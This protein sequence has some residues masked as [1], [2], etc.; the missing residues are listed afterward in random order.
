MQYTFGSKKHWRRTMWNAIASRIDV[1]AREA[2]VL[3]LGGKEDL[4][5]EVA[6]SK[7]FKQENLIF[8]DRS[9]E[10]VSLQRSRG[11]LAVSADFVETCFSLPPSMK[12]HAVFGD[13]CRGLSPA[14]LDSLYFLL[15]A[16]N[17]ESSVFAWNFLR[18][19]DPQW[20]EF[21]QCFD[22][23]QDIGGHSAKH[24]GIQF[25]TYLWIQMSTLL[26][27]GLELRRDGVEYVGGKPM[28]AQEL[29]KLV[30][31]WFSAINL[32]GDFAT[33]SYRSVAKQTFDSVI[34]KNICERMD[35]DLR[36][37]WSKTFADTYGEP[38]VKR[39]LAASWAHRT[40]R[41]NKSGPYATR[42][43]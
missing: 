13:F 29:Q 4:D 25:Q 19:R 24:R 31:S 23:Q 22:G 16:P 3:Y 28:S 11:T 38:Q 27:P 7:G 1:P 32:A 43:A 2:V 36:A 42:A 14:F 8:V 5:R 17:L 9:R 26:I 10:I 39:S 21:R 15:W 18:G 37:K 30:R 35:A 6:V 33:L 40:M 20:N 34:Y 41:Q 12:V